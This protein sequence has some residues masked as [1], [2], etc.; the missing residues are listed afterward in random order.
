M[1]VCVL[2]SDIRQKAQNPT[3]ALT[4]ATPACIP[5]S[6][7]SKHGLQKIKMVVRVTTARIVMHLLCELLVLGLVWC[8][9]PGLWGLV[10]DTSL[11]T[12]NLIPEL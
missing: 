1:C 11:Q 9:E 3:A 6:H 4:I 5:Q 12:T 8:F 2:I 7:V 10:G